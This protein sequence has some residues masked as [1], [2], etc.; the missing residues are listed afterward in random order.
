VWGTVVELRR[1]EPLLDVA[2][3]FVFEFGR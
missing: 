1:I 2:F 3:E